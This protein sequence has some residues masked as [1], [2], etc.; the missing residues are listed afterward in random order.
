[1]EKLNTRT[2]DNGVRIITYFDGKITSYPE[3]ISRQREVAILEG[4]VD[5]QQGY[6]I[7]AREL[8]L[9]KSIVDTRSEGFDATELTREIMFNPEHINY[10]ANRFHGRGD[11]VTHHIETL[12]MVERVSYEVSKL[13]GYYLERQGLAF[14]VGKGEGKV[15]EARTITATMSK[16]FTNAERSRNAEVSQRIKRELLAVTRRV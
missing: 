1:M 12:K 13:T 6:A 15:A 7:G 10:M 9:I 4:H 14:V 16:S 11:H 8:H 2:T 5:S 3:M